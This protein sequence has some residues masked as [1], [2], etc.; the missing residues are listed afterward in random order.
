MEKLR[1]ESTE[2]V[3]VVKQIHITTEEWFCDDKTDVLSEACKSRQNHRL[4]SEFYSDASGKEK[5]I[6]MGA[7]RG[8]EISWGD[9]FL[10]RAER[11]KQT[12]RY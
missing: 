5:E 10:I 7:K 4:L 8:W 11:G 2:L 9:K 12:R 3:Q 6:G 1:H